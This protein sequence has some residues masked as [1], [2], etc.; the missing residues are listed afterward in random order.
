MS[1]PSD[2]A[3]YKALFL[4][5]SQEL[6]DGFLNC[7]FVLEQQPADP[8]PVDEIFRVAHTLKGM[9]GAMGYGAVA[10]FCHR[11]ENHL[12]RWRHDRVPISTT[13]L[14]FMFQVESALRDMTTNLEDIASHQGALGLFADIPAHAERAL[15]PAA[16]MSPVTVEAGEVGL[17]V[18]LEEEVAYPRLRF[19]MVSSRLEKLGSSV[20]SVPGSEEWEALASGAP[21]TF[22]VTTEAAEEALVEAAA[23]VGEVALVLLVDAGGPADA[24]GRSPALDIAEADGGGIAAARPSAPVV[25]SYQQT[26]IRV[27]RKKLDRIT[28][29]VGEIL[30]FRRRL[31]TALARYDD[32]DLDEILEHIERTSL[33]LE[34]EVLSARMVPVG[35]IFQRFQRLVRELSDQLGKE[36]DAEFRGGDTEIDRSLLDRI[37]E[38][39][40]HII[41]N[42]LDHG[43]E[44]PEE[45]EAGGKSRRGSLVVTAALEHGNV[46]L[47]VEDDG[48]GIDPERVLAAARRKGVIAEDGGQGWSRSQVFSL[49]F[50]AGFSTAERVTSVSGRGV[51]LDVVRKKVVEVGGDIN[52]VSAAGQ[53]TKVILEFPPTLSLLRSLIVRAG[54]VVVGVPQNQVFRIARLDREEISWVK[55]SP[56]VVA[57]ETPVPVRSLAGLLGRGDPLD[58]EGES[59]MFLVKL[60]SRIDALAISGL[61]GDQELVIKPLMRSLSRAPGLVGTSVVAD[62]R[63]ALFVD[64][65]LLLLQRGAGVEA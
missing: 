54:D 25:H 49:L 10:E 46:A 40:V 20:R 51:G 22:V 48:R 64:L 58:V 28:N 61:V 23:S 32:E 18:T 45:R 8:A 33:E 56:M 15:S 5:E 50:Q 27:E 24:E 65:R 43:L 3:R 4:E 39:L 19:K 11:A 16:G 41:R 57:D 60:S 6:L 38:P 7:L 2:E 37:Q 47:K 34:R 44:T 29:M 35:S 31:K 59:W 17:V 63:L 55:G 62:G 1:A 26:G 30:M 36:V 9:A 52:L 14:E 12:D 53:G 13:D 21:V 42:S